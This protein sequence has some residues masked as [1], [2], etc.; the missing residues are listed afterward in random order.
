MHTVLIRS[1]VEAYA[2]YYVCNF[3][4]KRVDNNLNSYRFLQFPTELAEISLF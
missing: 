1:G 4:R 2:N 3:P